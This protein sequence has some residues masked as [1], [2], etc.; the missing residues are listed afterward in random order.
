[1]V[2]KNNKR[3]QYQ[4]H[5]D[6]QNAGKKKVR[7]IAEILESL[8]QRGLYDP[9][10]KVP[11]NDNVVV[12]HPPPPKRFVL[13]CWDGDIYILTGFD[14]AEQIHEKIMGLDWVRMPNGSQ[15]KVSSISKI[16]SW[17]DYTFQHDQRSRHKRGQYLAGREASGWYSNV[18]GYIGEADT[19]AITAPPESSAPKLGTTQN[20]KELTAGSNE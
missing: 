14:T 16:Q 5:V 13:T 17:E 3:Q 19:K 4:D 2:Q 9:N 7:S 8:K 20:V 18:D 12:Y 10:K 6:E 11:Q 15:I 1:M